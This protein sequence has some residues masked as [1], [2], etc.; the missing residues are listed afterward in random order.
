MGRALVV[1]LFGLAACDPRLYAKPEP[2]DEAKH[3]KGDKG[4]KDDKGD[5]AKDDKDDDEPAAPSPSP[6]AALG[7]LG[8]NRGP[9]PWEE[10]REAG[11]GDKGRAAIL[12]LDGTVTELAAPFSLSVLAGGVKEALPL[13]KLIG[14][15]RQLDADAKVP[16]ILLR[17]RSV[18]MSYATAEELGGA[19]SSL[20][21]PVYCHFESAENLELVLLA[22]C[23][24]V[25]AAPTGQAFL[26]GPALVPIYLK[27]LLDLLHVEPDFIHIGAFKGAAEPLTRTGPSPEMRRT[28]DDI[29]DGA[30]VRMIEHVATGRR[31]EPEK[32][33]N[34][35]DQAAFTADQAKAAGLIDEVAT[36]EAFRD[37]KS[38]GAWKRLDLEEKAA[39]GDLFALLGMKPRKKVKGPH[40]ALL[41]AVGEVK[42]GKGSPLGAFEEITSGRLVPALRAAAADEDVKAIVMR[43]DSPGG[44][45]LA[46]EIIWQAVHEAIAKKPVVVSMGAVAGSGG[47]YISSG[48]TR[49]FAAPDTLTGSIG[50]IGGKIVYGAALAKIG[51]TGTEMARGKRALLYTPLRRWNDDERKLVTDLM[52]DVYGTFKSR[53]AAGRKM[54]VEDVEKIAQ[55]RVWTGADAKDRGL[56]DELGTL[57]D[58]MAY[59]R[60]AG[61]LKEDAPVDVY[62]A[63]PTL[64]DIIAKLGGGVRASMVREA[65]AGLPGLSEERREALARAVEVALRFG[66]ESVRVIAVMPTVR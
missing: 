34:W 52:L 10:P 49:I 62:P 41:Y 31:V 61:S 19:L 65:L 33:K 44:S 2:A 11:D 12:E 57:D 17:L 53:V 13:R 4:H 51:V 46:S 60:K 7:M 66:E 59:A 35:I 6:L 48:A 20:K 42:D 64:L 43:V 58:A 3:D 21:K 27:G 39:S 1:A 36:W 5:K 15:L 16:A 8:Q 25:A 28:Y 40:V 55:G 45:A 9:G 22:H 54:A 26:S 37:A 56:V 23:R 38:G 29:L 14:R 63:E 18:K 50:V 47:Y 32:V 24:G 30:Y